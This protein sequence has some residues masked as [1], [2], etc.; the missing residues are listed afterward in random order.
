MSEHHEALLATAEAALTA[1]LARRAKLVAL[2]AQ[3]ATETANNEF[4]VVQARAKLKATKKYVKDLHAWLEAQARA[5]PHIDYND[6]LQRYPH[7]P[8][9]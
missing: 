8:P 1:T 9:E 6:L 2:R 4:A 7:A 3:I 5:Q